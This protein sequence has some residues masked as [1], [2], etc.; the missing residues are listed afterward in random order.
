MGEWTGTVIIEN[1]IFR[2]MGRVY[3]ILLNFMYS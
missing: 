1:R 2:N 3:G